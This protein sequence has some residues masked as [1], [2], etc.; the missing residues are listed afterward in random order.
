M[1]D[2]ISGAELANRP[3][4]V[5]LMSALKPRAGFEVLV[6]SEES[7]LGREAIETAYALKQLVQAGV[8]VFFYLED[9]ERTLDSPTD[10]IMLSLAT[11][12]DE[13]ERVKARQRT[14][15]AMSRKARAGHVTGGRVFGDDNIE[16]LD[17]ASGQRSHVERR[18]NEAE[19]AVV[20]R[21]FALCAG[22][23]GL[24]GITKRL[25]MEGAPS[26]RPQQG[27]PATWAPSSVRE[28]LLRPL[29]RGQIVWNQTR[30]RDSWG[31]SHRSVRAKEAWLRVP[32]PD[33]EIVSAE[34]WEAAQRERSR[35]GQQDARPVAA[36]TALRGI[37]RPGWPGA[38]FRRVAGLPRTVGA[39][40]ST[41]RCS[42]PARRTGSAARATTGWWAGWRRSTPRCWPRSRIPS[43]GRPSS[44]RQSRWP[45]RS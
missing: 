43:C 26:P 31:R 2:G 13:L 36:L 14:Y 6:M 3:G 4:F 18:I 42:M 41:G 20:Q 28:V 24:T 30:K 11:F 7:R 21:I 1:D 38:R 32:A 40:A 8:R 45:W 17:A 44:N 22:G 9:R 35:R 34:L 39:T 37:S 29:Y 5:R 12:A 10:K 23:A 19:A 25:N 15:D 27:R 16:I 33:L